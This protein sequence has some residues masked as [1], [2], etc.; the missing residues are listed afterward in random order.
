MTNLDWV[1]GNLMKLSMETCRCLCLG[2]KDSCAAVPAGKLL[3]EISLPEK[4][5][6][7]KAHARLSTS[8]QHTLTARKAD[9][10]PGHVRT[11]TVSGL[12][13]PVMCLYSI[14][15]RLHQ[16]GAPQFKRDV[17]KLVRVQQKAT[18]W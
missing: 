14:L 3:A 2:Q 4:S 10:I 8:Q 12:R 6:A 7:V 1:M 5:L 18:K 9:C 11:D 17:E 13:D 15:V 16:F